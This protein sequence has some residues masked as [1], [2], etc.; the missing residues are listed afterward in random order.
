MHWMALS[1]LFVSSQKASR[2]GIEPLVGADRDWA[3]PVRRECA[4]L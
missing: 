1:G 4:S 2:N 3:V